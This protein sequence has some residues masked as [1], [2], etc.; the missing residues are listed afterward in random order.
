MTRLTFKLGTRLLPGIQDFRA[1][2]QHPVLR[3]DATAKAVARQRIEHF[4][5]TGCVETSGFD[6]TLAELLREALPRQRR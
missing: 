5:K 6:E 3:L 2:P 1:Q 4:Q